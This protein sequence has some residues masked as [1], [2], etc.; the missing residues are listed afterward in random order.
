LD[1]EPPEWNDM[2]TFQR[3]ET[4]FD[5]DFA[6]SLPEEWLTPAKIETSQAN[7]RLQGLRQGKHRDW[8]HASDKDS[9]DDFSYEPPTPDPLRQPP[10]PTLNSQ[11]RE[12]SSPAPIILQT[13]EPTSSSHRELPSS[14]NRQTRDD[15]TI[16]TVST[17]PTRQWAP[18]KPMNIGTTS[19]KSYST[20][21]AS[22]FNRA[23]F[24]P[25]SFLTTAID[26]FNGLSLHRLACCMLKC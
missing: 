25:S 13:R 15:P 11:T 4:Y 1:N 5:E 24:K 23:S 6:P 14:W 18:N 7:K 12:P 3:Y 17:R 20:L 10:D 21:T 26:R 9:R 22:A 8:Q 19:G 2:C 16:S